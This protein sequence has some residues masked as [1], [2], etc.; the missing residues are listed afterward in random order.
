MRPVNDPVTMRGHRCL[1]GAEMTGQDTHTAGGGR[2]APTGEHPAASRPA[3]RASGPAAPYPPYPP[4]PAGPGRPGPYQHVP[5]PRPAPTGPHPVPY[6]YAWDPAADVDDP[7]PTGNVRAAFSVILGLVALLISLRPLAF[8][9][10]LMSWDT[11]V[12]LG[13]AVVALVLGG[14]TLRTPGCRPVAVV[15]MLLSVAALLVVAVLPT[16]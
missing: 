9:S 11:Y 15:G 1:G 5:A 14:A 7:R 4:H 2:P 16:F 13:I 8:G 3:P 12:A 10:M 6:A